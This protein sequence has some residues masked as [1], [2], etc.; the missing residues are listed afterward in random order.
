MQEI[1][2]ARQES[3]ARSSPIASSEEVAEAVFGRASSASEDKEGESTRREYTCRVC[4]GPVEQPRLVCEACSRRHEKE[5][6]WE[7]YLD[8]MDSDDT[9]PATPE[10]RAQAGC[11]RGFPRERPV[12]VVLCGP[13]HAGKSTFARKLR[14]RF[15][16]INPD[17]IRKRLCVDFGDPEREA[18]VWGIY[19]SM[20][21]EALKEGRNVVLDACHMSTRARWHS[22]QGPNA[23]HRKICVVFDLPF[24][25]IRQRWLKDKRMPLKKVERMWRDFQKSKP[26]PEELRSQGFDEVYFVKE[27]SL[28]MQ[29]RRILRWHII[30]E[31]QADY[32]RS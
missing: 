14:D 27:W 22:L 6:E 1:N 5:M 12:L 15:V 19:E 25:T 7:S 23:H 32:Q 10:P 2:N 4:D 20:K 16:V 11:R 3:S 30:H 28:A 31:K 21:C 9:A 8:F 29:S 17:K 26:T 24:R 13:S 18:E